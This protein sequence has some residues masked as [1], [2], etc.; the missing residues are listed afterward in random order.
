M[1]SVA[2]NGMW[3]ALRLALG[4]ASALGFARFAYGLLLPAMRDDLS[5]TLAA[6]GAM[7]AAN[8]FGYL[9]GALLTRGLVGRLGAA[10][11]FRLAMA[12][13]AASLASTAVSDDHLT[14]MILRTLSGATGAVVFIAGGVLASRLASGVAS[15]T[16][17]TVYF[18]GTG[19]GIV[20][21]GVAVPL[22][23]EH[24]RL[25]WVALGA[26]AALATAVSWTAARS[27]AEA[28]VTGRARLGPLLAP[29]LAYLLF[30]AGYIT[31]ITFLSAYLA[32]H[33]TSIGQVVLTWA[34]L[35]SAVAAAPAVWTRP[36]TRW[37]GNRA[38]ATLL[39]VMSAGAALMLVSSATRVVLASAL[40]YGATFMG[41]PA[42]VTALIRARTPAAD[43]AATLALFTAV[44][45]AGQTA[46]PW[47]A[48]LIA[49][50]TSTAA[51]LA[52]TAVLGAAAALIALV[53]APTRPT[54]TTHDQPKEKDH[55]RL[56]TRTRDV[57]RR[58]VLRGPHSTDA[59]PRAQR[60]PAD[61]DRPE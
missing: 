29:A 21:S 47:L 48:G 32:D 45:A 10:T 25:A 22:L 13:T 44:F 54:L 7:S 15:G 33:D 23:G 8:G 60:P 1:T 4:T 11:A 57:P 5:W 52:W 51:T 58:L 61:V 6:A 16:P 42:A 39:A 38:L 20:L 53:P 43:W 2:F 14:L 59:W 37:P 26:A 19:L 30:A 46:G 35:G 12:L 24:W 18:A 41:V 55:D 9:L 31:Y 34:V 56:R 49:D 27:E 40:L 17:I 28:P 36:I 3:P 50:R